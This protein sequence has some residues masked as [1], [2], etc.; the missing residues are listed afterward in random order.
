MRPRDQ[1]GNGLTT[2]YVSGKWRGWRS[3][4]AGMYFLGVL[5]RGGIRGTRTSRDVHEQDGIDCSTAS[6]RE[7]AGRRV[8]LTAHQM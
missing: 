7:R 6:L 4:S 5:D 3:H 1:D 2:Y 8:G